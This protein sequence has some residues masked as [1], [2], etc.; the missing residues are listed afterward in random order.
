MQSTDQAPGAV[1]WLTLAG[2]ARIPQLGYGVW[3]IDNSDAE[4]AVGVALDAG[5]RL[6]DTAAGY[7]NEAGVGAA[8]RAAADRGID[9][10]DIFVTTKL[11]NSEHGYDAALHAFDRSADRL[12]LEVVDLYLIHWPRPAHDLYLPTWRAFI[13][14][15]EEGRVRAIG[16]SNFEPQ[17]LDRLVAETGVAPEVNQVELHPQF[18]QRGLCEYHAAHGIVTEAWAPIGAG[19]GLL[20][21][22]TL[23]QLAARNGISPAQAVLAWHLTRGH[24]VIPKS[25]DP[26][27]TAEN[28]ASLTVLLSDRELSVIDRLDRGES[29]RTGSAPGDV[30]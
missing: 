18:Q 30:N 20:E 21:N 14:L 24:V 6:I 12:G 23:L 29:G 4:R 11:A 27:R 25:S 15:R 8:L 10:S 5:Y 2:G 13:R 3:R 26:V 16:V 1:Q 9:R 28:Y 22:P 19:T 17:H 7:H